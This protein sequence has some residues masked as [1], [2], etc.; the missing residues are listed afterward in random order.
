MIAAIVG[1]IAWAG[2]KRYGN[3]IWDLVAGP[4][5]PQ[6]EP[7]SIEDQLDATISFEAM[8]GYGAIKDMVAIE[9]EY[10]IV[11]DEAHDPRPPWTTLRDLGSA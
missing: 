6:Y 5:E 1:A 2:W 11:L 10:G 4:P 7:G 9:H 8:G 3:A